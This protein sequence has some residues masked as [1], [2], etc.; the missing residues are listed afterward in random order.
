RERYPLLEIDRVQVKGKSEPET[1]FTLLGDEAFRGS[2]R[3]RRLAARHAGMIAAYRARQWDE[4]ASA[5]QAC[6][7]LAQ[8]LRIDGLYAL[9]AGR[10]E[11]FR[12]EPQ[13]ADWDGVTVAATK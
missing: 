6:R 4:T 12:R 7:T 1:L 3:F 11:T 5:A 9:Y 13:P 2:D 8:D 10:A